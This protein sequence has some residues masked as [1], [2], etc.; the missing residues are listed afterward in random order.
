MIIVT[1]NITIHNNI[2]KIIAQPYLKAILM[3]TYMCMVCVWLV[4]MVYLSLSVCLCL[5][6]LF[7]Q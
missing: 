5:S 4:Y 3:S 2:V 1:L 7:D 6:V